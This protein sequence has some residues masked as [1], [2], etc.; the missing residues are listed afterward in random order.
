[1]SFL[2]LYKFIVSCSTAWWSQVGILITSLVIIMNVS[3]CHVVVER[4][5]GLPKNCGVTEE[6]FQYWKMFGFKRYEVS[7]SFRILNN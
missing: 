4:N 1:V 2:S 3:L 7:T 6:V 5:A